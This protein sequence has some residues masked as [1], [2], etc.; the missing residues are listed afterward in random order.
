LSEHGGPTAE[1][2]RLPLN[3]LTTEALATLVRARLG[4]YQ[5]RVVGP[6]P[7]IAA[8]VLVP[9]VDHAGEPYVLFA[10]RTDR[11]GHHRGQISFP[12]GV[13]DPGDT[14]PLD[15]AL[16]EAEEEIALPRAAVQPL[17]VLDDTE[18][19]ATKFVITPIVG[20][21]RRPVAWQPDGHEIEKV[22]EVPYGLLAAEGSC[23]VEHWERDGVTRP[24][25]FFD[26]EGESIWGATARILVRFLELLR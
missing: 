15:A 26:Y 13:I 8:A 3:A 25:Y 4:A 18:T 9:I 5:R 23:R 11:V 20:V 10:K 1:N 7:L 12:G 17:G 22:I 24:V 19:V 14:S 21:V 2:P 6:G 16:R